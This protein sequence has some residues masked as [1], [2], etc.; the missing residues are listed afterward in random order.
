MQF[1]WVVHDVFKLIVAAVALFGFVM[2]LF[3]TSHE[4]TSTLAILLYGRRRLGI[5]GYSRL[6]FAIGGIVAIF[7]VG[8]FMG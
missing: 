1:A 5:V 6:V 2:M 3:S 4:F 8:V 7:T